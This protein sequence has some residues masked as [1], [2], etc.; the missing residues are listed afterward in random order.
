MR[1]GLGQGCGEV[2]AGPSEILLDQSDLTT[3]LAGIPLG[4]PGALSIESG[5][6]HGFLMLGGQGR[7]LV[8]EEGD[9]LVV[10]TGSWHRSSHL[11]LLLHFEA[12]GLVCIHER[13]V[14]LLALE[15]QVTGRGYHAQDS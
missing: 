3:E 7:E 10:G 15:V 13:L 11:D 6:S 8:R 5:S 12:N 9:L 2:V 4:K 1:V 14:Q